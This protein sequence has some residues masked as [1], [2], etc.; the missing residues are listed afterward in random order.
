M[1]KNCDGGDDLE[2]GLQKF[3]ATYRSMPHPI[4][5]N[6]PAEPIH[7]RQMRN[8]LSCL[9]PF[10]KPVYVAEKPA[11]KNDYSLHSL[12]YARN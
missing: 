11:S 7:G 6:T 4:D 12:V 5:W 9:S 2:T 10:S 8:M 1:V 3:L